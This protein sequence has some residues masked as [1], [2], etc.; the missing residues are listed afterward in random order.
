[1]KLRRGDQVKVLSGKDRGR[2]GPVARVFKKQNRLLVEG[3]NRVKKHVKPSKG[4]PE[5]G[6]VTITKPLPVA[7]LMLV[8]PRCQRPTRVGWRIIKQKKYRIC[9]RCDEV[10]DR[11]SSAKAK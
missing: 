10:I 5:G 2:T 4:N 7:K 11:P 8:C 9:R 1:M 3:I 6:V